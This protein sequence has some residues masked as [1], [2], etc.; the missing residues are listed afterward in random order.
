M[1]YAAMGKQ[2]RRPVAKTD[3]SD[4][5][6]ARGHSFSISSRGT[7]ENTLYGVVE[8]LSLN[9]M[10]LDFGEVSAPKR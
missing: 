9:Y 4:F 2:R 3:I 7:F 5:Q 10:R 8:R 6:F 1:E